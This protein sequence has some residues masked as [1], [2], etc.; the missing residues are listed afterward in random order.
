MLIK[1]SENVIWSVLAITVHDDDLVKFEILI[2]VCQPESNSFLM[3]EVAGKMEDDDSL[4]V[5]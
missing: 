3:A 5:Y 4:N 1:Q 2:D